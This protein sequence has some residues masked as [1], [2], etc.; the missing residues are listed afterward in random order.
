VTTTT[1]KP[2]DH[3]ITVNVRGE[4]KAKVALSEVE[5]AG[6]DFPVIWVCSEDEWEAARITGG[7]PEGVPWPAEDVHPANP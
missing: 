2:G 7:D 5:T 3:V 4:R 1:I 6:H